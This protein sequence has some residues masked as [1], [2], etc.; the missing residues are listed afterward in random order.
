MTVNVLY[1]C[2]KYNNNNNNNN[3]NNKTFFCASEKHCVLL[4][5]RQQV[6]G[7]LTLR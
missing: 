7:T 6:T 4:W 1:I 5:N 2:H 3:N